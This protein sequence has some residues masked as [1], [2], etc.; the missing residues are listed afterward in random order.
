M[1][2]PAD[3]TASTSGPAVR[4]RTP[5]RDEW[6]PQHR[7]EM[8]AGLR[9]LATFLL[10]HPELRCPSQ[11][12]AAVVTTAESEDDERAEVDHAAAAMG[13]PPGEGDHYTATVEFGGRVRLTVMHIPDAWR[14]HHDAISSYEPNIRTDGEEQLR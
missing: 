1:A 8:A 3:H 7:R 11:I 5:G 2:T 14:R 6:D 4:L 12:T 13:V 10:A 9:Q